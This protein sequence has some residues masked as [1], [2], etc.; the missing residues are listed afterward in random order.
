M[1]KKLIYMLMLL[2]FAMGAHAQT[3]VEGEATVGAGYGETAPYLGGVNLK[4]NTGKFTIKPYL[5]IEGVTCYNSNKLASM[6]LTYNSSG[7]FYT[8]EQERK[9]KGYQLGYGL[10]FQYR[11]TDRDIFQASVDGVHTKKRFNGESTEHLYNANGASMNY[12]QSLLSSPWLYRDEINVQASY[13]HKTHLKG[14]SLLLQYNY[15]TDLDDNNRL[16]YLTE[17]AG[18][19]PNMYT[20]NLITS[21]IFIHKHEVLFDWKRPIADGQQLNIGAKYSNNFIH[22]YDGQWLDDFE[23]S[24]SEFRHRTQTGGVYVGYSLKTKAIEANARVEYD[25]THMQQKNLHD[26]IPQARFAYHINSQNTLI[27]SYAMCVIRPTLQY[28]ND[29]KVKGPYTLEYGN[30]NLEGA[31]VNRMALAYALK[32]KKIDFTTTVSHINV[33]D[34]F[35]AIWMDVDNIRVYTWGNE[36][37]RKA[38]D[39]TPEML[40]RATECTRLKVAFT[41]LWDERIAYP[42]DLFN[43]NWGFTGRVGWEQQLPYDIKLDV[44]AMISKGNTIDV[45]SHEGL[46]YTFSGNLD[47]AFLGGKLTATLGYEY[48]RLPKIEITQGTYTGS[49]YTRHHNPNTVRVA[50]TYKF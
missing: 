50:L 20:L 25:Y 27:A 40:W 46:N 48:K 16:Q 24:N 49:I 45:Y 12:V 39:I 47:R 31:H 35:N 2:P 14:E 44:N 21:D 33:T 15:S 42:I 1:N 9:S 41:A 28:L 8:Q 6:E 34:G 19:G 23:F 4:V 36:G 37:V 18:F 7:N 29:N 17:T 11:L 3:K 32:T 26:V 13:L 30:R 22:S 43:P 10:D 38:I 5:N